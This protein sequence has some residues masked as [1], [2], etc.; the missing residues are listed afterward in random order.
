[1]SKKGDRFLL[2]CSHFVLYS[3]FLRAKGERDYVDG[4]G[5]IKPINSSS[6]TFKRMNMRRLKQKL[7]KVLALNHVV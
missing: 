6:S 5:N 1:M 7:L 2:D 3:I 4:K